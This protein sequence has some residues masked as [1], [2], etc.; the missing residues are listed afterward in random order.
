MCFTYA[1]VNTEDPLT[2][3]NKIGFNF[4]TSREYSLLKIL[5]DGHLQYWLHKGKRIFV[6][7]HEAGGS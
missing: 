1:I 2:R 6:N 4:M 5:L 3:R 7:V